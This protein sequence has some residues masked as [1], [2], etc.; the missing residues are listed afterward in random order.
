MIAHRYLCSS[1]L[2]PF[3]RATSVHGPIQECAYSSR[4]TPAAIDPNRRGKKGERSRRTQ[5]RQR[6]EVGGGEGA[7]PLEFYIFARAGSRAGEET[8]GMFPGPRHIACWQPSA[9]SGGATVAFSYQ[10]NFRPNWICRPELAPRIA[11]N[12]PG[13]ST[14]RLSGLLKFTW[15]KRLKNSERNWTL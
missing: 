3:P 4:C 13:P 6:S 5:M 15:L 14:T 10:R 8:M 9:D 7:Q 1:L 12:T 11:P 2:H